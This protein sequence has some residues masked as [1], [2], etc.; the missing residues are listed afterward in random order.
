MNR[1]QK[2]WC[3]IMPLLLLGFFIGLI[4][5]SDYFKENY[6]TAWDIFGAVC[7]ALT[8]GFFGFGIS[9]MFID[10]GGKK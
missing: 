3:V 4:L 2:A 6:R 10:L 5:Y 9:A 1:W 7:F 8:M